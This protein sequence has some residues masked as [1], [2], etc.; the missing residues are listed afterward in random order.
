[1]QEKDMQE[2]YVQ[3]IRNSEPQ[4]DE[5]LYEY[6]WKIARKAAQLLRERYGVN[7]IRLFG[8]LAHKSNFHVGS[9]IDLAVEGLKPSDYWEALSAVLF[10]DEK[11]SI[12]ILDRTICSP[13]LWKVI[14]QEG[15]DL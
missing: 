1:M 5:N 2:I 11:V 4:N 3:W 10:L 15:I 13:E 9:D 6:S 7:R 8:S 14:E 12:E